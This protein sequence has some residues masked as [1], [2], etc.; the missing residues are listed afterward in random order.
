[1]LVGNLA[2]PTLRSQ[3]LS[4]LKCLLH[5][6]GELINPHGLNVMNAVR[7]AIALQ[8]SECEL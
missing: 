6:L 4:G 5:L 2:V 1:M 7:R 3:I 8:K